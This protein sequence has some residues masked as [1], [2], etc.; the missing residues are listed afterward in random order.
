MSGGICCW[1]LPSGNVGGVVYGGVCVEGYCCANARVTNARASAQCMR[2]I[3]HLLKCL[4]K[5]LTIF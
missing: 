1:G 3:T 2:F 4:T 5:W